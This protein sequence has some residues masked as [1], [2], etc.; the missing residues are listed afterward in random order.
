MFVNYINLKHLGSIFDELYSIYYLISIL[1]RLFPYIS[2]IPV[3]DC[4]RVTNLTE[5]AH[6]S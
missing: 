3:V 2:F 4:V 1:I 5:N 6:K